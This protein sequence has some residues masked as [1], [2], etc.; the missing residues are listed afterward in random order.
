LFAAQKELAAIQEEE[1]AVKVSLEKEIQARE[2]AEA[3]EQ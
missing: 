1:A 2:A 3:A